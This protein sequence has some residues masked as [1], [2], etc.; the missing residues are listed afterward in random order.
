MLA[1]EQQ[2]KSENVDSTELGHHEW[3]NDGHV[4]SRTTLQPQEKKKSTVMLSRCQHQTH[5]K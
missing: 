1:E 3:R 4:L 5:T 2:Q